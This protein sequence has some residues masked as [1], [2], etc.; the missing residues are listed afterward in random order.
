MLGVML[1]CL[2]NA[3]MGPEK[4]KQ[5]ADIIKK[6][7]MISLLLLLSHTSRCETCKSLLSSLVTTPRWTFTTEH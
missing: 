5:F 1:D 7:A 2:R 3:V 6:W 4:V